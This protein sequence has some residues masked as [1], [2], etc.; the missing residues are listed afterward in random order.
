MNR[1][2][3][4]EAVYTTK[5]VG[6]VSWYQAEPAQSLQLLEAAGATPESV[7]IDVGD[8][9][10]VRVDRL[11][12][13]GFRQLTV[14]DLSGAALSRARARL[15]AQAATVRWV[16]ADITR[17]ELLRDAYDVWHDRA[18]FH[19]LTDAD[20]RARYMATASVVVRRGG[21]RIIATFAPDGPLR[22]SG[23]EVA[24]YSP[25]SIA[26]EFAEAFTLQHGFAHSH[27]T[28]TGAEQRFSFAVLRRR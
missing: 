17:A 1:K 28:P 23:L 25:E 16:E 10:S 13:R 15:G 14:L 3:H 26:Q 8:G 4:W 20:D 22:C 7:I 5:D 11:V 21:T 24:R 18:V 6:T 9:D 12:E 19:S 2:A 27:T